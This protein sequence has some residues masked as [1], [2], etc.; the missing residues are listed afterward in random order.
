M[1]PSVIPESYLEHFKTSLI[2]R[3][4]TKRPMYLTA[5]P[6]SSLKKLL[7][8][9]VGNCFEITKSFRNSDTDSNL[10]NPEFSILEWYR[11][12]AD[13]FSLMDD[14]ENLIQYIFNTLHPDDK[15]NILT[16]Q[17]K[18][19]DLS[20]PWIRLTMEKA[21]KRYAG[22]SIKETIN[23]NSNN[24]RSCFDLTCIAPIATQKGYRVENDSTWE[25]VFNQIFLN[26]V[27]P[28]IASETKPVIL[29]DYPKPMA[30]LAKVKNDDPAIAQRM[31]FYIGGLELGDGYTELTD[32]A[33]QK[34]R[35]LTDL[36]LIRKAKKTMVKP[37]DDFIE[38]LRMGLPP[39]AGIAIGLDRLAMLFTNSDK[40]QDILWF[41]YESEKGS[42]KQ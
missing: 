42:L 30:A 32:P 5:S 11:V 2:D 38:A 4:R 35:F 14:C 17:N 24:L 20:P 31:E 27:E 3:K 13:Y 37:D 29:Y 12:H 18:K 36:R 8:A 26:E 6:E 40:I 33:E 7:T 16:Y 34:K 1:V 28:H 9:G 41:P 22:I 39:C 10:H 23:T 19:I 25:S 21:F 15:T